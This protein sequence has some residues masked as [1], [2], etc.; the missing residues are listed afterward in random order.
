MAFTLLLAVALQAAPAPNAEIQ[1]NIVVI[2]NKMKAFRTS[3][4]DR[5]GKMVCQTKKSTGDKEIDAIGC[6]VLAG[7]LTEFRPRLDASVDR[8]LP[9]AERTRLRKAVEGDL[10]TCMIT[11][12]DTLIADLAERRWTARQGTK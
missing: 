6:T 9:S 4:R 11:R 12:R 5:G 3:V 7:C 8:K 2:G 1:S 10:G